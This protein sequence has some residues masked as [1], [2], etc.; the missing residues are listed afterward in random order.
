MEP[1]FLLKRLLQY[2]STVRNSDLYANLPHFSDVVRDLTQSEY[3]FPGKLIK[4]YCLFYK[5]YVGKEVL[6]NCV[7]CILYFNDILIALSSVSFLLKFYASSVIN[8]VRL[9]H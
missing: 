1:Q 8:D 2:P 9:I 3:E 6:Q 4:Q 7:R 5:D